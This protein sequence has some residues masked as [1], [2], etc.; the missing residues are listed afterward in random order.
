MLARDD[1]VIRT[2]KL[3]KVYPGGVRRRSTSSTSS[4]QPGRDLRAARPERRGQ[5]H[6]RRHA[7]DA[8]DPDQRPAR[9]SAASTSSRIPAAAKQVIGVVPQTNTLDRSLD[10][11]GEPLLPRPLLRDDARARAKAEADRLLEQFRLADRGRRAGARA[12]GRHGAAA[13]GGAGDH[14]PARHRCSSTSPPPASTR[15]AASRCG[16]SSASST[17]EGQTI[18][19]T[20]HYMEE[21]DQLCDR[22]AIID[23]G[24]LLALGTPGRAQARRPAP[25]PSSPSPPTGDLDALAAGCSRRGRR[26]AAGRRASTAP[27]WSR[28]SGARACCRR[29]FSAAERHGFDG[30]RP[31]GHRAD[32]RDRVHQPHREGPPRMTADHRRHRDAR[33]A[34]AGAAARRRGHGVAF[35]ALLLR[36]LV[37]LRKTL[38]EFIPRTMLQ[39]FLL[40]FVFTYVFPKI[41]QGVGGSGAG[42]SEFSTHAR[43]RR[44]RR[45]RSSSR[46]SSR[47]SL[48]MVQEFGYTRE[49]ED[50]V[51]APLPVALVA[52][53]EGRRRARSAACSP[54]LLVFPIAAIVPATPV[55][56]DVNWLVLL[57]LMPL[58]CYMCGALG[59]TFG[60]R[61]EPRTVPMLF[62]IIVIPITFLG[63]DLL[64]VAVARADPLAADRSC[65]STRSCT[66]ARGSGPRSPTVAAHEPLG[67][68]PGAARRVL[69]AVHLARHQ[70][71]Q[72]AR[73]HL[74]SAVE[75]VRPRLT[76]VTS[77]TVSRGDARH[78]L[79]GSRID[80]VRRPPV[81]PLR[82]EHVVRRDRR[83]TVTI[84]SSSISAPGCATTA[85]SSPP[86]AG[87][88]ATTRS[89]LLTHLHWD[90]IQGLPFFAP[91]SAG[92]RRGH[93]LRPASRTTGPLDEVFRG[94]MSPPYF[95]ITPERA[96]RRRRLRGRRPATTSRVNGAKVRSRWVRHTDPT[97][98]FRVEIEGVSVAYLSDHGPGTVP[99]DP[100]DY[101][102]DDVLDLCDGVD[103]AHPRRAAHRRRVRDQARLGSLHD[104]VRDPRG[105]EAGARELA[106]FHHCPSHGD[107]RLDKI[108]RDARDSRRRIGGPEVF[109]AADGLRRRAAAGEPLMPR[110]VRARRSAE[111]VVARR[112][113]VPRRVRSLR[114]RR[115]HH[116]RDGRRRAGRH[117]GQLV[118]VA[119]ARSAARAVLRRAHVVHLAAHRAAPASSRSTSS[120]RTTR[121]SRSLFAQKGADRFG[122]PR[123]GATACRARRCS[124][125]RSPT[126]TASSRPSTPAATTRSSSGRVL[127]LDMREGARPLLFFKGGY[128]RMHDE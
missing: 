92:R 62:G 48:P 66:C 104:R 14:A 86:R 32:A 90:H 33:A 60:T 96:P 125:R 106:L 81:R 6:D 11:V 102:P 98:G 21:A 73:P 4:V 30:H 71:V 37:V 67:G 88:T 3:T 108:L 109:A 8:G 50:R 103:L 5:D 56:L 16:R 68:L 119:V 23:H 91:L 39:P 101:V 78:L 10:R 69:G 17:R 54:A 128:E 100:D 53:A 77:W 95:P 1:V 45:S 9:S 36:D 110:S 63:C 46:A 64:P 59:L 34:G 126:S 22:L 114:H 20:T 107:D 94:V 121:S 44:G 80:S 55:H 75:G 82:R 49:I 99:D 117:G 85:S 57:T 74:T 65:S 41:G 52:V 76:G 61:F 12:V 118:H 87:S 43:R 116:H 26:R 24:Q 27:S 115:H 123:R 15:R 18:L 31:L 93:G 79:G 122:Q 38:K 42:E 120:A 28:C 127:D 83:P 84:P 124:R 113:P 105:A 111:I 97:L 25:T 2:E 58:A 47:S 89:V 13:H 35:R 40:V 112:P 7:H 51:L 72:A 29:S 70:R 19:L